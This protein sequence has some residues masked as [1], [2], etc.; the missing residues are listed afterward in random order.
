MIFVADGNFSSV[1]SAG[2]LKLFENDKLIEGGLWWARGQE[3]QDHFANDIDI[4]LRE[5]VTMLPH[6]RNKQH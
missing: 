6:Y 4:S 2:C 3:Q 5:D 1:L